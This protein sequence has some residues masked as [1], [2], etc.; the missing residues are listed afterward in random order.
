MTVQFWRFFPCNVRNH[1][2]AGG[3]RDFLLENQQN[4][5]DMTA[6]RKLTRILI[7]LLFVTLFILLFLITKNLNTLMGFDIIPHG[8][9]F[10]CVNSKLAVPSPVAD[11]LIMQ[12]DVHAIQWEVFKSS[13]IDRRIFFHE[14]SGKNELAFRQCCA[15]ESAAKHN[16][17]RPVQLFL[18]PLLTGCHDHSSYPS[19][20]NPLWLDILSHYPNIAA[21][22]V[23]EHHYF[24]GTSFQNWYNAGQWRQSPH[25]AIHLS[26]YIRLLT[27]QKG[28]GLYLDTDM[29]TLRTL[30][31]DKFRN[32][33][34]YDSTEMAVVSN[35]VMHMEVGHWLIT[36]LMRLLAE[37]YDPTEMVFHG[38]QA[39]SSVMHSSC[40]VQQGDPK[41]NS[42][43]D[44]HLLPS[45]LFFPIERPFSGML[46]ETMANSTLGN[47]MLSRL[48]KS[49]G[50]HLWHA[51]GNDPVNDLRIFGELARIHCPMT[52]AR[53]S[54]FRD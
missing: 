39:V 32:C 44:I 27:L 10:L 25:E 11:G 54:E 5:I 7:R 23:N 29:L 22:L 18:R 48:K 43:K 21:I 45:R 12:K 26:D 47:G 16:P 9:K 19:F 15:I 20:D 24:T 53:A 41:S 42:C 31:G 4:P 35:G 52:V 13:P 3:D 51:V 17:D 2:R 37:E 34:S 33:L 40:G 14:T 1:R 36:E 38:C 30:E 49:Y 6:P 28:G 8:G 46:D 50:I